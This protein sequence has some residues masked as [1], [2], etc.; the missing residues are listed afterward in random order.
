M[1]A[2]GMLMRFM[3]VSEEGTPERIRENVVEIK[4]QLDHAAEPVTARRIDR[5]DRLGA[6]LVVLPRP[7]HPRLD[8]ADR[9]AAPTAIERGRKRRLDQRDHPVERGAEADVLHILLQVGEAVF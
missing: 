1:S 8:R 7:D 2:T 3:S 6:D 9:L 5:D 4:V